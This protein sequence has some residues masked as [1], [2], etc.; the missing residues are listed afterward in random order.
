LLPE[1]PA[2]GPG[3]LIAD[4]VQ[5]YPCVRSVGALRRSK[6]KVKFAVAL[7]LRI[8]MRIYEHERVGVAEEQREVFQIFCNVPR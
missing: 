7:S 3:S 8:Q 5:L 4:P 2:T 6:E 1:D